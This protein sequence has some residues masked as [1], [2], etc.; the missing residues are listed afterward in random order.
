MTIPLF[1]VRDTDCVK[2]L[3]PLTF[4]QGNSYVTG[5]AA[6]LRRCLYAI[7]TP[8]GALVW[9]E[10]SQG[11]GVNVFDLQNA[12]LS[13]TGIDGWKRAI[14]RQLKS[15]D[16]V[17]DATAGLVLYKNE[18]LVAATVVLEDGGTYPL[19]V[20][21]GEAGAAIAALGAT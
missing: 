20:N 12:T 2:T 7:C 10:E 17:V 9:S 6:V 11:K 8:R 21:I 1:A 5:A 13:Q 3:S 18:W 15:V 19:E 16:Y 14:V 4:D